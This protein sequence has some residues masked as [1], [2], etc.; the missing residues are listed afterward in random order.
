MERRKATCLRARIFFSFI[1][2][3]SVL[4]HAPIHIS[5]S[6]PSHAAEQ[7]TKVDIALRHPPSPSRHRSKGRIVWV[8]YELIPKCRIY[9]LLSATDMIPKWRDIL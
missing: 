3:C 6:Q 1:P 7:A 5:L 9:V 4:C 2:T 8:K